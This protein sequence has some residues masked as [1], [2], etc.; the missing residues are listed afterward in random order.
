MGC[1]ELV[2]SEGSKFVFFHLFIRVQCCELSLGDS[3]SCMSCHYI[4]KFKNVK[5]K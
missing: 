2:V 3:S 4:D 1:D 5:R